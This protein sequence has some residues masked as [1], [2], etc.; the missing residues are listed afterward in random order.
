MTARIAAHKGARVIG[1]DLVPERL[2][3]AEKHGIE[4]LNLDEHEDISDPI[5]ELTEGRGT[6][7][8][9]D[10]VGME[11]HGAPSASSPRKQPACSQTRSPRSW[12]KEWR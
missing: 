2:D 8:A 10:A 4:T 1:V 7:A 12:S 9:I 3:M 5:R 11:A 6:D